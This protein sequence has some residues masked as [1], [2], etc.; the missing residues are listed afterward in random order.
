MRIQA[1][2]R[3]AARRPSSQASDS[4]RFA[5]APLRS[6]AISRTSG[7]GRTSP[8]WRDG[9]SGTPSRLR[10]GSVGPSTLI[11]RLASVVPPTLGRVGHQEPYWSMNARW[12][13]VERSTAD[14][15]TL[16]AHNERDQ[17]P[18]P[19]GPSASEAGEHRPVGAWWQRSAED[20]PYPSV[21]MSITNLY[22]T[23]FF[24]MRA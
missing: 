10:C 19:A 20:L 23:S 15:W 6:R 24:T 22:F 17:H 16:V 5:S 9:R 2:A 3:Q 11:F 14:S 7:D 13:A 12:R 4:I 8:R 21:F 18:C 1:P